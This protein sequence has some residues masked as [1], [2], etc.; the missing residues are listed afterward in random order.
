MGLVGG[1]KI[2]Q[3]KVGRTEGNKTTRAFSIGARSWAQLLAF[4][5]VVS[6]SMISYILGTL[7]YVFF[8]HLC[9]WVSHKTY[10]HPFSL[11]RGGVVCLLLNPRSWCACNDDF[12][13]LHSLPTRVLF[14]VVV[15]IN[16][17]SNSLSLYPGHCNGSIRKSD[18]Y[19]IW[20][21]ATGQMAV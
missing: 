2:P 17:Q 20:S 11:G 4:H 16:C 13:I 19:P 21:T 15:S 1:W 3:R 10:A 8:P 7:D 12:H 14:W 5:W 18:T 6:L 9:R